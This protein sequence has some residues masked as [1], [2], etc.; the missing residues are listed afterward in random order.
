MRFGVNRQFLAGVDQR[1]CHSA[2]N[3][4]TGDGSHR[5]CN[6]PTCCNYWPDPGDDPSNPGMATMIHEP[7]MLTRR[8]ML[9][10]YEAKTGRKMSVSSEVVRPSRQTRVSPSRKGSC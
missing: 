5:C 9:E 8:E 10:R 6:K 7:G 1:P 4:R 2:T 3:C